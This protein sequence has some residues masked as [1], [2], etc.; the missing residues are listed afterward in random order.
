MRP[1]VTHA[2]AVLLLSASLWLSACSESTS[3][4]AAPSPAAPQ[5]VTG[6]L[7]PVAW[8]PGPHQRQF[9]YQIDGG[10]ST[11]VAGYQVSFWAVSGTARSLTVDYEDPAGNWQPYLSFS[12]D[13]PS[14]STRPDGSPIA[15]GDSVLITVALDTTSLVLHFEPTGLQFASSSPAN[16]RWWYTGANP[17]L[18][19]DGVVNLADSILESA[20]VLRVQSLPTDPWQLL[21]AVQSLS[22]RQ[23][24]AQLRHFSGYAV[25]W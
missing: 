16:L 4:A 20:L 6:V 3:P 8:A 1:Y 14:L 24:D 9:R 23:F 11:P 13:G 19:G 25:S 7:D 5:L 18:N 10:E 21:G 15:P 17:D 2:P 12:L 22:S